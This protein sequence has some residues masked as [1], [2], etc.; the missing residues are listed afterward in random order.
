MPGLARNG[1]DRRRNVIGRGRGGKRGERGEEL[2]DPLGGNETV[3]EPRMD[4]RRR[5]DV[6]ARQPE[7]G[8]ELAGRARQEPGRADIGEIADPRFRHGKA[9]PLGHDPMAAMGGNA[10]AAPITIPSMIAI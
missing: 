7:I 3:G 1:A 2:A 9:R 4:D 6:A 8:T 10:D 5:T